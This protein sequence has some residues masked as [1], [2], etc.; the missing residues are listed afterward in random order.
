MSVQIEFAFD[1]NDLVLST[2]R[3]VLKVVGL[4]MGNDRVPYYVCERPVPQSDKERGSNTIRYETTTLPGTSLSAPT[5]ETQPWVDQYSAW[6]S[7]GVKPA[8]VFEG[9]GG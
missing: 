1:I 3:E 6:V 2:D 8:I 9:E 7:T 5:A 4:S